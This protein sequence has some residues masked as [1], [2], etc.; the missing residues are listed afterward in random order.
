MWPFNNQ[1]N[2]ME[3]C[4]RVLKRDASRMPSMLSRSSQS[5]PLS[6]KDWRGVSV[7][8]YMST[9]IISRN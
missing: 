1:V 8:M 9:A 6:L 7:A 5:I 3:K 2:V 4:E